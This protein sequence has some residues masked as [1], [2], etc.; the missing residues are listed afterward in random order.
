MLARDN[1]DLHFLFVLVA[2]GR[3]LD[4]LRRTP[5][6]RE[7]EPRAAPQVKS[8]KVIVPGLELWF[9]PDYQPS[10]FLADRAA[11]TA[12]LVRGVSEIL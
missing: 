5:L 10:P 7:E 9:C 8:V 11:Q 3:R 4:F 1:L 12:E 6:A 2:R